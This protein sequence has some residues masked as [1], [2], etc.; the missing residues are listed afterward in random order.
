MVGREG[1]ESMCN[2]NRR[3]FADVEE[4]FYGVLTPITV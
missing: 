2:I 1:M 3:D 4:T